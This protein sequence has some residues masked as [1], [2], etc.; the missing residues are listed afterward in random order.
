MGEEFVARARAWGCG[1]S[2]YVTL[3]NQADVGIAEILEA[4]VDHEATRV[5]ALYAEGLREG[6][7]VAEAAARV[8]AAGRPVVL[9][10]PGRSAA[11]ARAARSHTGSLASSTAV[12]DAVCRATGILRVDS[13]REL[14]E[15]TVAL[16]DAP[17]PRGRRVAVITEGGGHGGIAAD[18]L[19]AAG[20][21][22]P[23]FGAALEGRLREALPGSAGTNPLDFA[24]G[25]TEPDAYARALPV[26]AGA[27]EVDAV[28]AV[29]QL[30][31]WAARFPG[32]RRSR[33]GGGEE[34]RGHGG[35]CAVGRLAARR[36]H[37]VSRRRAGRSACGPP[38]CPCTARSPPPSARSPLWCAS[39]KP[40]PLECLVFHRRPPRSP[41]RR[42]TGR[43]GRSWPRPA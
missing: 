6:R 39:P 23:A 38:A 18:A 27:D 25:T 28:F 42:T 24:L 31:Y 4:F 8:V 16:L 15:T 9:L 32:A 12:L 5:V 7:R 43:P 20:L 36:Q 34:R 2:R 3:G 22:V 37:R 30:G 10:A 14:F 1:F 19:E 26:V 35:E 21:R 29:G 41:V 33:G 40:G 11:G 13:P 17:R